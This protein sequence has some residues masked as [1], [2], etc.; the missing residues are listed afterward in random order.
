M[1]IFSNLALILI[2][3]LAILLIIIC[4]SDPTFLLF[5]YV[6]ASLIDWLRFFNDVALSFFSYLA[7]HSEAL[8]G[9]LMSQLA[10]GTVFGVQLGQNSSLSDNLKN[11]G[12]SQLW[13][14]SGFSIGLFI[15]LV[16]S[17]ICVCRY[18]SFNKRAFLSILSLLFFWCISSK[19]PSFQRAV[20]SMI[21]SLVVKKIF[22]LQLS[23]LRLLIY[24]LFLL[25]FY[26]SSLINSISL[27]F[28]AA[29][30]FGVINLFPF[31][32]SLIPFSPSSRLS[33]PS[34][35]FSYLII[36]NFKNFFSL[37]YKNFSL[38]LSLQL[39]ML[40][41]IS[42]TW[43]EVSLI[44]LLVNTLVVG[45]APAIFFLGVF[46]CCWVIGCSFMVP[47]LGFDSFSST[48]SA[49]LLFPFI[50]LF[51]VAD[52]VAQFNFFQITVPAFSLN[53]TIIWYI[54]IF[55]IGRLH[56][57]RV[58]RMIFSRYSL[59]TLISSWS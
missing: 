3:L 51:E 26:D 55:L 13:S 1:R 6:V 33:P 27:R 15:N 57:S 18:I 40:P 12:M 42:S 46:W 28:S 19:T 24:V 31:L 7:M 29:A 32:S 52:Q 50:T 4:Q 5:Y 17:F 14:I 25:V 41:L 58:H 48:L 56:S 49:C 10:L 54:V 47:F 22:G 9:K 8:V 45:L 38:F 30:V 43:G 34:S 59:S 23:G 16:E 2:T 36:F 44:S 11:I 20:I 37:I 21:L 53:I 39:G 35:S